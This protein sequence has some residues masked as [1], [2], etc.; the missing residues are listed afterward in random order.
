MAKT[1]VFKTE[2]YVKF[3]KRAQMWCRTHWNDKGEQIIDWSINRPQ[4]D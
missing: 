1:K 4:E 3:V 2:V